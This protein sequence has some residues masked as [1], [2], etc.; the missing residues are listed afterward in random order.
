MLLSSCLLSMEATA[1]T[2]TTTTSTTT[3]VTIIITTTIAATTATPRKEIA[4]AT[5]I[6]QCN[7]KCR[8]PCLVKRQARRC[9]SVY[10]CLQ[11]KRL[12]ERCLRESYLR[13]SYLREYNNNEGV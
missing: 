4:S 3:A 12:R 6:S 10:L 9:Y 1:T 11:E 2:T 5:Q 13:E 7:V 8:L